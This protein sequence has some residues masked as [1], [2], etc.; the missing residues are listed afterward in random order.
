MTT[1]VNITVLISQLLN[2]TLFEFTLETL[3]I[4]QVEYLLSNGYDLTDC[5]V[6]CSNKGISNQTIKKIQKGLKIVL[7]FQAYVYSLEIK[8]S[9]V[10]AKP[11]T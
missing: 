1:T 9:H 11:I 6:N 2:G 10:P 7:Y 8:H 5:I 3:G 4:S